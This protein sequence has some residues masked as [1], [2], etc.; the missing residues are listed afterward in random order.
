MKKGLCLLLCFVTIFAFSA[1]GDTTKEPENS[2]L[3]DLQISRDDIDY[4]LIPSEQM[5]EIKITNQ[6]DFSF[7]FDYVYE[8]EFP[9]DRL[10]ELYLFPA[11]RSLT[12]CCGEDNNIKITVLEDGSIVT[13]TETT[14]PYKMYTSDALEKAN[15]QAL[16]ALLEKYGG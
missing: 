13:G 5:Q 9:G 14:G 3:S 2:L 15:A 16:L 1:C 12:I 11:A 7:L 8:G 10:H 6:N 4:V